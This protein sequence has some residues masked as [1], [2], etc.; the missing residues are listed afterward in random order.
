[1][2]WQHHATATGNGAAP[3]T[4]EH[5]PVKDSS[6]VPALAALWA[7][8]GRHRGGGAARLSLEEARGRKHIVCILFSAGARGVNMKWIFLRTQNESQMFPLTW[9]IFSMF[10]VKVPLWPVKSLYLHTSWCNVFSEGQIWWLLVWLISVDLNWYWI[11]T[12]SCFSSLKPLW[13]L[14]C[15]CTGKSSL[16]FFFLTT[17]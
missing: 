7:G 8:G 17:N 5:L 14:R 9:P 4:R 10:L 6:T 11:S 12:C 3:I 15:L 13:N 2:S 16:G 1:M